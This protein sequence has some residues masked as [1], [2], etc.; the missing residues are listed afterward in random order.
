MGI[1]LETLILNQEELE[2]LVNL[3]IRTS[4]VVNFYRAF[5]FKKSQQ[6]FSVV[7][8]EIS[9]LIL[10]LVSIL[11]LTLIT[12]KNSQLLPTTNYGINQLLFLLLICSLACLLLINIYIFRQAKALQSLAKL[13]EEID[14]YNEVIYAIALM[15]YLDSAS[16]VK[17]IQNSEEVTELLQVTKKSLISAINFEKVIRKHQGFLT[18][19]QGLLTSL[20]SNLTTLMTFDPSST[21]Q[22]YQ[23]ILNETLQI[24][25]TVHKEVGRLQS[26][27]RL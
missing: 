23:Q 19:R 4:I 24:G 17:Y 6:I 12:L 20:E 15:N 8:T 22:E 26:R 5:N 1:N 3:D 9:L 27:N 7:I 10:I 2:N 16:E 25:L 21:A 11:P 18:N 13:M 14:K